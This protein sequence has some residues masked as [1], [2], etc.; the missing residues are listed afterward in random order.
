MHYSFVTLAAAATAAAA[1]AAVAFARTSQGNL[2]LLKERLIS[3]EANEKGISVSRDILSVGTGVSGCLNV[4][5]PGATCASHDSYGS[6]D[7]VL[8]L[9]DPA[10]AL[11]IAA[12]I[13]VPRG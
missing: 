8:A 12:V 11:N 7:C 2:L 10:P 5:G 1:A 3:S 6:N 9:G 13:V 4:T